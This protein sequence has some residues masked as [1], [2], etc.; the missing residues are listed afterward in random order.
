[1]KPYLSICALYRNEASYLLEWLEFHRLV[2]VERFFLYNNRSTDAH[3]DVLSP[4][5]DDGTVVVH[6]FPEFPPQVPAY[7][8]CLRQHRDDSRWI[9]FIDIDE[10]LF[11]PTL[12]PVSEVLT[13]YEAWPGVGVH[14]AMFG[15][16]G[17][18]TRPPGLVIESYLRRNS[19]ST[20]TNRQIKSIVDPARAARC[21]GPHHFDYREGFAVDE[22][23][24]PIEGGA[25]EPVSFS[26]LRLNHYVM[27]SE[28]EYRRKALE[29]RNIY[30]GETREWFW[31]DLEGRKKRLDA[32]FDDAITAY[33]PALREALSR[34]AKART[35]S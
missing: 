27:K 4:F 31:D 13:E 3:R 26:R 23:Q 20:L 34:H 11:S 1:V 17:H 10:F 21:A 8:D 32:E 24:R 9:A 30:T 16:S 28:E 7:E 12:Q 5:V 6:D 19:Q 2:G 22:S 29:T 33:V 14:W 18:R 25:A 35:A 15:T